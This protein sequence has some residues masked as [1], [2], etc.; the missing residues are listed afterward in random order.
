MKQLILIGLALATV[1]LVSR[2][3]TI[4][5][6]VILALL[7]AYVISFPVNWIWRRTGWHRTTVVAVMYLILLLLIITGPVIIV[8]RW[9]G[10]WEISPIRW[11]T[12]SRSYRRPPQN[13]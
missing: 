4:L 7:L 3:E 6:P 12:W 9:S 2:L 10:W 5:A 11:F 8:P 1:W 13:R